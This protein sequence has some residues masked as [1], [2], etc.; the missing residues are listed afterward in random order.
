MDGNK[1]MKLDDLKPFLYEEYVNI[2]KNRLAVYVIDFMKRNHIENKFEN[3]VICLFKL[4]PERFHLN[5]YI[6]YPDSSK[7]LRTLLQ[8]RP[9]YRNWAIPSKNGG[10]ELIENG[11]SVLKQTEYLLKNP[12]I[13]KK[14]TE[15]PRIY[16]DLEF[17]LKS[18]IYQQFTSGNID[19]IQVFEIYKLFDFR[20]HTPAHQISKTLKDLKRTAKDEDHKSIENFLNYVNKIIA[21]G[22]DE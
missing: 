2:D 9:K 6:C 21:R 15:D 13:Q 19:K 11:R 5:G 14:G 22:G 16:K 20:S 17:I 12:D 1:N 3:I 7:V 8:L 10:Y 18:E 4:F